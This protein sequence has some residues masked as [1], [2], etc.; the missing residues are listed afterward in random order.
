VPELIKY[1]NT[2]INKGGVLIVHDVDT[3]NV[4][5]FLS[6]IGTPRHTIATDEIGRQLG[7]FYFD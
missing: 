3:F 5:N 7:V 2:K 4:S 1:Y 6:L